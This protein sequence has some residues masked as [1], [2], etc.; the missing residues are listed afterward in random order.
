MPR[1]NINLKRFQLGLI[2]VAVAMTLVP[3]NSTLNRVM[4]KELALSATLVAILASLPYIFSPI[5]VWIGAASD[6]FSILGRRR[7]PF[8]LVGLILCVAGVAISPW[9][10]FSLS[11]FSLMGVVV[12]SL[13]FMFWGLGYNLASVSYLA[14][15]S[16]LSSETERGGTIAVM[17]FMMIVSIIFTAVGLGRMVEPYS[18]QVLQSAFIRIS[19]VALVLGLLGLLGLEPKGDG[20]SVPVDEPTP[21]QMWNAI[22]G[23][24]QARTFFVYLMLLLAAIL[25]QDILLE[26]FAAEAFGWSVSQT[27]RLTS[28]WGGAVLL[29]IL[30]AGMLERWFTRKLVAQIGNIGA[31]VG[32]SAIIIGGAT[33]NAASFYIGVILLGAGTGLSTVANLALMFD[34]TLPGQ[35]GLYIGAWGLSNA[36]S[37]LLGSLIGGILRDL[38]AGLSGDALQ[39]YLAV[40]CVEGVLLLVAAMM[41]GY[42]DVTKFKAK[43][44]TPSVIDRVAMMD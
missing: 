31:L 15:A 3:I 4:I 39:G 37:R 5:Q 17:W 8:I 19:E 43:A 36:L 11:K 12:G 30:A 20:G 22:S 29:M 42:I 38:A 16:E 23:N 35:V 40:F 9:A 1:S 7:T 18:P 24:P 34:L 26:P 6:R 33:V 25:G 2:H 28:L 13:P 10:A 14:L 44:E 21:K 27:T 41:L 32:F